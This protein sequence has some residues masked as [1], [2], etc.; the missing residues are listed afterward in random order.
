MT[1]RDVIRTG[2]LGAAVAGSLAV[3]AVVLW[4]LRRIVRGDVV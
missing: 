3:L 1:A 2:L 4:E